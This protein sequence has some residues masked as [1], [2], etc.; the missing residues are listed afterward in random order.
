MEEGSEVRRKKQPT[1]L[2]GVCNIIDS[3]G[4]YILM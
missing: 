3:S 1:F 4:G 2:P